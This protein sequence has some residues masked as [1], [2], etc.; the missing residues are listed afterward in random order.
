MPSK[1]NSSVILAIDPGFDRVG[2]AIGYK[3]ANQVITTAHG[4]IQTDRAASL[5]QRYFQIQ[6]QVLQIIQEHSPKILAIEKL[7]FARNKTTALKVSEARG[8]IIITALNAQM[9]IIELTPNEIKLAV[10]GDGQAD[11]LA[12]EKMVRL[13][14]RL[15]KEKIVDDTIDALAILITACFQ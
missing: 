9:E 6:N 1:L 13:Q 8:V 4:L 2:W 11:K 14:L 3:Q 15:E 7:F 10:A 12:L 5:F